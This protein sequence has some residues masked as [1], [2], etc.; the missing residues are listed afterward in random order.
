MFIPESD[1]LVSPPAL[2][3]TI[4]G[5]VPKGDVLNAIVAS[6]GMVGVRSDLTGSSQQADARQPVPL[7]RVQR[8]GIYMVELIAAAGNPP[9]RRSCLLSVTQGTAS[10]D[11]AVESFLLDPEKG[12]AGAP[13][14]AGNAFLLFASNLTSAQLTQA[15][16]EAMLRPEF[17]IDNISG[18]AVIC[19]IAL[20]PPAAAIAGAACASEVKDATIDF[21]IEVLRG[22]ARKQHAANQL[23][24][25]QLG[26]IEAALDL[27]SYMQALQSFRRGVVGTTKAQRLYHGMAGSLRIVGA[28]TD[29][30][31]VETGVGFTDAVH[32]RIDIA[33]KVMKK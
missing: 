16:R 29:S 11:F 17:F 5:R 25:P 24:K 10:G 13:S 31:T 12:G 9:A 15:S 21:A 2:G 18:V 1:P 7:G 4:P 22:C 6:A 30:A 33:I 26:E 20:A 27:R 23:T 19:L 14:I 8:P 32:D 28:S 3:V